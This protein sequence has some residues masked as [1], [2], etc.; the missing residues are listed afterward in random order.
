MAS[1]DKS[2]EKKVEKATAA[3]PAM[4][5]G[6]F[7]G[8]PGA[9]PTGSILAAGSLAPAGLGSGTLAALGADVSGELA[10]LAPTF[11]DVLISIGNGVASSQEALD[12]GLVETA[13]ALS[14]TNITV[15]TDVIQELDDDGLPQLGNTQLVSQE[16][17]LINY[18]RP[19][20]HEWSH[21]ALSMDLTVGAMDR[22]Q[23]MT[24]RKTMSSSRGANA[25]LFFGFLGIGVM[26]FSDKS[27]FRS[28]ES[29]VE[30]N[31]AEGRVRMDAMLRPRKVEGFEPPAE[32]VI[33]PQIY[34]AQ[35]A[36]TETSASGVVTARATELLV[37]VR[38]ADGSANPGV[39]IEV[40]SGPFDPSFT[41]GG[42]F[43][44]NT[45]NAAGQCKLALS[46]TIPSPLFQRRIRGTVTVNLGQIR[47]QLTL[48]L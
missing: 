47:K 40:D 19:T 7:S 9:V 39:V 38:K 14:R 31:W 34:L 18:V 29:E 20:A 10:A 3:A 2:R 16:V 15:V 17:S 23:G 25:G 11:G 42:G 1:S 46:R 45:T 6:G 13:N 22:D 41:T 37:T 5:A 12:R 8:A 28:S 21:V 30:A 32:V 36:V 24:F 35:G 4:P 44:G 26:G 33:G 48:S 27:T 43:N